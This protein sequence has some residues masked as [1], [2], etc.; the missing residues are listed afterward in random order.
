MKKL[1]FIALLCF[2]TIVQ[3][4]EKRIDYTYNMCDVYNIDTANNTAKYARTIDVPG[5]I[6]FSNIDNTPL[7]IID[8]AVYHIVDAFRKEGVLFF[9]TVQISGDDPIFI[10]YNPKTLR[11][12]RDNTIF[13]YKPLKLN[14]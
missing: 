10:E 5:S 8:Y 4:Q 6:S 7:I 11:I 1:L 3:A 2:T 14:N 13:V 9:K 12:T